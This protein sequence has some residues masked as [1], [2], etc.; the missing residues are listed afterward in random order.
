MLFRP[1]ACWAVHSATTR[2]ARS[3]T[4]RGPLHPA[5]V[6]ALL[7]DAW[8]RLSQFTPGLPAEPTPGSRQNVL[9]AALTSAV[10]QHSGPGKPASCPQR[11]IDPAAEAY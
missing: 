11:E 8:H 2:C 3:R 10:F 1:W 4:G 6:N 9:L 7:G 5:G